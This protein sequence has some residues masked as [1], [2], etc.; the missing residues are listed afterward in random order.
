MLNIICHG[1]I[2]NKPME[3][4]YSTIWMATIQNTGNKWWECGAT[5]THSSL[6]GM[7]NDIFKLED[8][9]AVSDRTQHTLPI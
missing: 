2:A 5:D 4:C 6:V 7:K 9:V 3:Y 1:L 8:S